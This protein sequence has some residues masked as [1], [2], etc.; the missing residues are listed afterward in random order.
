M[1]PSGKISQDI[2]LWARPL[3]APPP[4]L[5][6]F[7]KPLEM[8]GISR[9]CSCC[10][11]IYSW[12]ELQLITKTSEQCGVCGALCITQYFPPFL[13]LFF[14]TYRHFTRRSNAPVYLLPTSVLWTVFHNHNAMVAKTSEKEAAI[15]RKLKKPVPE[16]TQRFAVSR[17]VWRSQHTNH[18]PESANIWQVSWHT[19][20]ASNKI[21][22]GKKLKKEI[23][24]QCSLGKK[25]EH[26]P[27]FWPAV[28][29]SVTGLQYRAVMAPA[30]Q[31]TLC[32][33]L[34]PAGPCTHW[35]A[36]H[37]TCRRGKNQL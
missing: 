23:S 30:A 21:G 22:Q 34:Q 12:P 7:K 36:P 3:P 2:A 20:Q 24:E 10:R 9:V 26:L 15:H 19:L 8:M 17:W 6:S 27:P 1:D 31:H 14:K 4:A 32:W 18:G 37:H 33:A 28:F 35:V 29:P 11:L 25:W 13:L 16:H 5:R